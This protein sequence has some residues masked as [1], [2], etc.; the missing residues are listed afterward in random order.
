V[1]LTVRSLVT[2]DGTKPDEAARKMARLRLTNGD[3]IGHT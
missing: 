3:G 1:A 2:A